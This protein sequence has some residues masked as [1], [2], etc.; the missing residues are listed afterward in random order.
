MIPKSFTAGLGIFLISLPLLYAQDLTVTTDDIRIEQRVDGGYHLYIRKKPDINSVLLTE[1]TKDPSL[2]EDNYAYR[3]PE[4]N[5]INGDEIRILDGAPIPRE[6][7]IYSL[8]DST[9]EPH[10]ELGQAFHIYIPYILNYGFPTTR[11]GEVYVVD[12]TYLNIRSF[13]LPYGN[14]RDSFRDNPF[15]IRLIQAPFAG[16]PE[17]NYMKDT[18]TAFQ[19]IAAR[20]RGD[21]VYSKGPEDLVQKIGE[22][23][24]REKGKSLDL[25]LCM[26]TTNSMKDDIDSV[27][28]LLIPMLENMIGEFPDFRIGMVLYKD[29]FEEYL[30]RVIPFT[31]DFEAVRRSLGAIRVGGGRDLPEAVYEALYEG[32]VKFPWEAESGLII[33]I[34]DAPPHA[35][36]RG[37]ITKE[38]VD[39]E[40]AARNLTV[41]A[42]ILPH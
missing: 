20:G 29:Y 12:G 7:R 14:Y 36:P 18:V 30:N 41:H 2:R 25:V 32:T 42:I 6:D 26:D 38:M 22:I 39:Q 31:R 40:V 3:A 13:S 23:L 28:A 19:E 10:P 16:P 17:G 33:L 5:P 27:R 35:R 8:I 9:P 4:W 15:V 11:H 37:R 24:D 34:G 21:L 1:S